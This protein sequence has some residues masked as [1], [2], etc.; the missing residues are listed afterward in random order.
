MLK[1]LSTLTQ[2]LAANQT[3]GEDLGRTWTR[4][5]SSALPLTKADKSQISKQDP[6]DRGQS[7]TK[8]GSSNANTTKETVGDERS[9]VTKRAPKFERLRVQSVNSKEVAGRPATPVGLSTREPCFS[10]MG[11]SESYEAGDGLRS[12]GGDG[13]GAVSEMDVLNVSAVESRRQLSAAEDK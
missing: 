11:R 1:S 4:P 3:T 9:K 6:T 2:I 10:R 13:V 8:Q 5:H 7:A 12:G